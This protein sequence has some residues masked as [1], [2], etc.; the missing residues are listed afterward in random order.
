MSDNFAPSARWAKEHCFKPNKNDAPK[1]INKK[2]GNSGLSPFPV[3][4]PPANQTP[5]NQPPPAVAPPKRNSGTPFKVSGG[6]L[7]SSVHP[8]SMP[9]T[10]PAPTAPAP[11][12][13]SFSFFPG[14]NPSGLAPPPSMGSAPFPPSS[15]ANTPQQFST[16]PPSPTVAPTHYLPQR[17]TAQIPND[18]PTPYY[19]FDHENKRYT[20]EMDCKFRISHPWPDDQL[21]GHF[22]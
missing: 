14:Q 1:A 19:L 17:P 9:A 3:N 12:A 18:S 20:Q 13:A 2:E 10:A 15:I 6:G 5:V 7:A 21:R 16:L 4:S 8:S 22:Y 11:P